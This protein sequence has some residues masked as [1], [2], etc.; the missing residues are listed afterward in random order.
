MEN[1]KKE[2]SEKSRI[3][4]LFEMILREEH[5]KPFTCKE[6][7][8]QK[9]TSTEKLKNKMLATSLFVVDAKNRLQSYEKLALV[10]YFVLLRSLYNISKIGL[11]FANFK[12][13][14]DCIKQKNL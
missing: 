14:I 8:M 12:V 13:K 10:T 6:V 11:I 9:A 3:V 5:L 7:R 2:K 1:S 4:T